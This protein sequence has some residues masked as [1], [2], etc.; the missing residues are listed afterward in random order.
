MGTR[1]AARDPSVRLSGY[2]SGDESVVQYALRSALLRSLSR[3]YTTTRYPPLNEQ[4][5]RLPI[6][7]PPPATRQP[8]ETDQLNSVAVYVALDHPGQGGRNTSQPCIWVYLRSLRVVHAQ[9]LSP[10]QAFFGVS[11]RGVEE[12]CC[13]WAEWMFPGDDGYSEMRGGV[14][15]VSDGAGEV[16]EFGPS[17]G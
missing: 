2:C 1:C 13:G 4:F 14:N 16:G 15:P 3:T 9:V 10:V 11:D 12:R 5:Y 6:S 17:G 7:S 8:A